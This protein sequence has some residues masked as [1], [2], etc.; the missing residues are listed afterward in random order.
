M[1]DALTC[2]MRPVVN[3]WPMYL[4]PMITYSYY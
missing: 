1:Q 2:A 3:V 4:E